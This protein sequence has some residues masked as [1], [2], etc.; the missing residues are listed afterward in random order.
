MANI[1]S[2][3]FLVVSRHVCSSRVYTGMSIIRYNYHNGF[4]FS[5][6]YNRSAVQA[7]LSENM[8]SSEKGI[9]CI[10]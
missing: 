2:K 3:M 6:Y 1:S 7:K 8:T 10:N 5:L 9:A 4:R